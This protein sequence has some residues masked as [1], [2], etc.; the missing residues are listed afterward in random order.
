MESVAAATRH[1]SPSEAK[2]NREPVWSIADGRQ[3]H[4]G[5]GGATRS[6]GLIGDVLISTIRD[7]K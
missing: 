7:V 3:E 6:T 5:M 1:L 2:Q 4:T